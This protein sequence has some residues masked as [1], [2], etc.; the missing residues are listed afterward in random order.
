MSLEHY[1]TA[2]KYK[3]ITILIHHM[4]ICM[5]HPL[6]ALYSFMWFFSVYPSHLYDFT[7]KKFPNLLPFIGVSEN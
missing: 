6:C 3:V 4:D 7:L 1:C 2:T 5:L